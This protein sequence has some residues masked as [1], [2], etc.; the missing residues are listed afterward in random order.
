MIGYYTG[1]LGVS[2]SNERPGQVILPQHLP[3]WLDNKLTVLV[4]VKHMY[5]NYCSK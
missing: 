3:L 2:V 4:E 1:R 5:A